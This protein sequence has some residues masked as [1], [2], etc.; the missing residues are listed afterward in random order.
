MANVKPEWKGGG[1]IQDMANVKP[2]W[3]RGGE[4]QDIAN[5]N[6]PWRGGGKIQDMANVKPQWRGG[7]EISNYSLP[8]QSEKR[9]YH[10]VWLWEMGNSSTSVF[11]NTHAW[12]Q[13]E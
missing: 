1:K 10:S 3:R 7:S 11:P 5:V 4:M 2:Q 8:S 12:E 13:Q 9:R 6:P